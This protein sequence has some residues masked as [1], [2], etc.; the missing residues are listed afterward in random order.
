MTNLFESIKVFLFPHDNY[1]KKYPLHVGEVT[2][3]WILLTMLEEGLTL[4]QTS[5]NTTMDDE[6]IRTLQ[7]GEENTKIA[8]QKLTEFMKNEGIPLTQPP[9]E[10][11]KSDPNSIPIG[12]KY[13]DE[14]IANLVSVKLA[15]EITLIGQA[16][17]MSVRSDASAM[18][19]ET[20]YE[21]LKYG[22]VLKNMMQKRGWLKVPPY[23][24]PPGAPS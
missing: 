11:P 2:N 22:S 17:A 18:L 1:D 3:L 13:T 10:R 8:I 4:Y 14:E 15:A 23:Y 20:L 7:N 16:L 24:Y 6:L 21:M 19:L 12:A 5:L 9:Q